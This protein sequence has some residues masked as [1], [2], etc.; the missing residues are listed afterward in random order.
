MKNLVPALALFAASSMARADATLVYELT[1]PASR[2]SEKTFAI[3]HFFVRAE[4]SDQTDHYLLFQAGKFFPVYRVNAAEASYVRLTPEVHP[5][6]G[7]PGRGTRSAEAAA[8]NRGQPTDGAEASAPPRGSEQEPGAPSAPVSV[9]HTPPQAGSA[10]LPKQA[11]LQATSELAEVGG[12][13]CR[14]VLELVE[15]VVAVE[16]CMANKAALGIT[17]RETR[18]LAR[19]FVMARGRGLDWLGAATEDEEFVSLRSRD[20]LRGKTLTLKSI[21]RA[22]LPVGH[23]RVP[24]SYREVASTAAGETGGDAPKGAAEAPAPAPG[25]PETPSATD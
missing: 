25:Q 3:S 18:T 6:L 5:A 7:P 4:S 24:Q 10:N 15:G 8:A 20:K 11:N 12:I 22:P 14:V 1:D 21:S 23:L 19:L 9:A 16:H 13:R 2:T 17:E